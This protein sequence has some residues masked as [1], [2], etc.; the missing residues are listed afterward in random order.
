[1]IE[2]R[3]IWQLRFE[4]LAEAVRIPGIRIVELD[5]LAYILDRY[6]VAEDCA[7]PKVETICNDL[8]IGT[9][10]AMRA[11]Q[12]LCEFGLL[13]TEKRGPGWYSYRP[14]LEESIEPPKAD[15]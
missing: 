8:G 9:R 13:E 5:V 10:Q 2:A 3:R 6:N 15:F 12:R 7:W 11:V 14:R 1:M 4:L